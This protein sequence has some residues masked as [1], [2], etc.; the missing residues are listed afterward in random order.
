MRILLVTLLFLSALYAQRAGPYVG[1]S[2]GVSFYD[3]DKRVSKRDFKIDSGAPRFT[4]GAY[5][6]ESLSMEIDYTYYNKFYGIYE[7]GKVVESF[8]SMGVT[9]LPH[10]PFYHDTF[11]F[12]GRLGIA[13]VFWV[14]TNS[15]SNS[16][17]AGAYILGIGLGY[18][19]M[20]YTI[21]IGYDLTSFGLKDSNTNKSYDM[22]LDY[23]YTAIEVKF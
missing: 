13:Q 4:L 12:F 19:I 11:D 16:D 10:L 22:R 20:D 17:S 7:G 5:I 1:A 2:Y 18:K 15:R 6:N 9:V 3:S 8:Y 21:K 23:F 14:E